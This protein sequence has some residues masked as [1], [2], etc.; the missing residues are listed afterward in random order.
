MFVRAVAHDGMLVVMLFAPVLIGCIFRFF[1]PFAVEQW[2]LYFLQPYYLLFDLFL[3]AMTPILWCFA[4]A[5]A[6]LDEMDM[7][8]TRHLI[9]T[10]LGRG[11]YLLSRLLFPLILVF[12]VTLGVI[13]FASLTSFS[14]G[15]LFLMAFASSCM[16]IIP[17]LLI[18]TFAE[19]RVEGMAMGKLSGLF[20]LGLVVPFFSIGLEQY[21]FAFLPSFWLA[22]FAL[23]TNGIYYGI[24]L[25][26]TLLVSSL[27]YGRYRRKM[28]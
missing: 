26:T 28:V 27:L 5:L 22:K 10:P 16:S 12:P 14:W 23:T 11:G 20:S 17:A 24:T 15:T 4:S 1:I 7:G 18:V 3:M 8:V 13:S 25:L 19:N 9:V 2:H 21:L 6:M